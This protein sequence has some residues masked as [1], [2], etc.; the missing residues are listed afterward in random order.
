[1]KTIKYVDNRFGQVKEYN[2]SFVLQKYQNN[3]TA[4][5][6]MCDDG[7]Y[8]TLTKNL[9]HKLPVE[10]ACYDLNNN[11]QEFYDWLITNEFIYHTGTMKA[12]GW[13]MYPLVILN[14][15]KFN[16]YKAN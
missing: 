7:P 15:D 12:S 16:E 6:V 4:I 9:D 10:I 3:N 5:N 14:L 1:M 2:L 13:C 11:G 8:C